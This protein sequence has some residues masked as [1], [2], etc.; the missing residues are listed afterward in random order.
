MEEHSKKSHRPSLSFSPSSFISRLKPRNNTDPPPSPVETEHDA[1]LASDPELDVEPG[2]PV[3]KELLGAKGA[4]ALKQQERNRQEKLNELLHTERL[5]VRV[6]RVLEE[7]FLKPLLSDYQQVAHH[8]FPEL[9]QILS[10]HREFNK[11]LQAARDDS[12]IIQQVAG[13]FLSL[14]DGDRGRQYRGASA[15]YCRKQSQT[16][17]DVKKCKDPHLTQLI[18]KSESSP[19]CRHMKLKDMVSAQMQ[20]LAQYPVFIEDIIKYTD[21]SEELRHLEKALQESR[22][23]E[24]FVKQTELEYDNYYRLSDILEMLDKSSID[25]SPKSY[26][27]AEVRDL[28]PKRNTL[29]YDG[30]LS[31]K[32]RSHRTMDVHVVLLEN[33]M[34]LLQKQDD[35][36]V[37]CHFND[38]ETYKSKSPLLQR[39][40]LM[41]REDA[42]DKK[43]FMVINS[44]AYKPEMYRFVAQSQL[45]R[46]RWVK[47]LNRSVTCPVSTPPH[48]TKDPSA[49]PSQ[50]NP[51]KSNPTSPPHKLMQIGLETADSLIQ[52]HEVYISDPVVGQAEQVLTPIEKLKRNDQAL[53]A[54]LE[55]RK[56]IL[57][58]IK[59]VTSGDHDDHHSSIG[60]IKQ[61]EEINTQLTQLVI[62]SKGLSAP[63]TSQSL[64]TS[65]GQ[66]KVTLPIPLKQ[67]LEVTSK[68][69]QC[70]N[71]LQVVLQNQS[72]EKKRLIRQLSETNVELESVS[73]STQPT[74][75]VSP[76]VDVDTADRDATQ[77]PPV[78]EAPDGDSEEEQEREQEQ[79]SQVEQENVGTKTQN[80]TD[81]HDNP[82]QESNDMTPR[83]EGLSLP[84][85][86]DTYTED[87]AV[88]SNIEVVSTTDSL[89]DLTMESSCS[90]PSSSTY[91]ISLEDLGDTD[92]D[93][94]QTLEGVVLPGGVYAE[95]LVVEEQTKT[96]PNSENN[97]TKAS[98]DET[99]GDLTR[100]YPDFR[101]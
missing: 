100:F 56:S 42:A 75:D 14:F 83:S 24:A 88:N 1:M 6:L 21:D 26:L 13:V 32:L 66:Q 95:D 81:L 19:I 48:G 46:D 78:D 70:I 93:S 74:Q 98:S 55:E 92:T 4:L 23:V 63:D 71:N 76:E 87:S 34:V 37:L 67:L 96:I 69:N 17:R 44:Q 91:A 85:P 57:A 54:S 94:V 39:Q 8:L 43:A 27:Y 38:K 36:L 65:T 18:S 35:K 20:R 90:M 9:E 68:M 86:D 99:S 64:S 5:H 28:D 53:K 40:K 52:A 72:Y 30:V 77:Q 101:L 7:M 50:T 59:V 49:E 61:A 22:N 16:L 45:E 11:Q 29:V 41:A 31:M 80:E 47:Y 73:N 12:L 60:L 15:E 10:F 3:L 62:D 33:I 97:D 2:L 79:I 58:G 51:S 89:G 84:R 25:N 82:V